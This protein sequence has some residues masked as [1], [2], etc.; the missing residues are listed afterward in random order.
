[1]GWTLQQYITSCREKLH[2]LNGNFW[3]D[4]LLTDYIQEARAKILFETGYTRAQILVPI[5]QL[6]PTY[7]VF[8][9]RVL[10]APQNITP[11]VQ[12][13]ANQERYYLGQFLSYLNAESITD[14]IDVTVVWGNIKYPLYY[15]VFEEL[16]AVLRPLLGFSIIP[17][18][19]SFIPETQMIVIAPMPAVNMP[20]EMDLV[21]EVQKAIP[22]GGDFINTFELKMAIVFLACSYAKKYEGRLQEEMSFLQEHEYYLSKY[23]EHWGGQVR[24]RNPYERSTFPRI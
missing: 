18:G 10:G 15:F 2:D 21:F 1:M 12:F 22:S 20:F 5:E 4:Q 6:V 14:V 19:Y 13:S 23:A 8:I 3:S 17:V 9:S 16:N 11:P 24:K 7:S